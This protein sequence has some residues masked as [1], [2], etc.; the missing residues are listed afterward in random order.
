VSLLALDLFKN[1]FQRTEFPTLLKPTPKTT[2]YNIYGFDFQPDPHFTNSSVLVKVLWAIGKAIL[3]S[4]IVC[5]ISSTMSRVFTSVLCS[6]FQSYRFVLRSK[7][8]RIEN[9]DQYSLLHRKPAPTRRSASPLLPA[10][11]KLAQCP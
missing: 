7:P 1:Q 6:Q 5:R 9:N 11:Q 10:H 3:T 4:V 8:S 2:F